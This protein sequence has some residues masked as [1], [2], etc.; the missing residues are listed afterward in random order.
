MDS[1]AFIC[2]YENCKLI[3]E[4]PVTLP[5]GNTLCKHHLAKYDQTFQCFFCQE[6]HKMPENDGF[7]INK[8][9]VKMIESHYELNLLK[10]MIKDSINKL[11][12]LIQEYQNIHSDVFIYDTFADIR[13][14]VDLHREKLIE[15]I[16]KIYHY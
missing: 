2:E 16:N 12:Q 1:S 9:M 11:N 13:N 10:K 4:D 5:C 3:F 6:Q 8:S 14:K 7:A 15:E